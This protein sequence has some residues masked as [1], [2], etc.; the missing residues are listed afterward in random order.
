MQGAYMLATGIGGAGIVAALV[1]VKRRNR[2]DSEHFPEP[3]G[4]FSFLRHLSDDDLRRMLEAERPAVVAAVIQLAPEDEAARL[5]DCC[6]LT[7]LPVLQRLSS[8][9]TIDALEN[10]LRAKLVSG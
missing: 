7:E 5:R 2:E 3:S 10:A 9:E 6:D 4:P 8:E 1:L